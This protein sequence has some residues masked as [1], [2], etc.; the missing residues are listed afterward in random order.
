MKPK[1]P[2]RTPDQTLKA[3]ESNPAYQQ[4]KQQ[5]LLNDERERIA[6]REAEKQVLED[7][8]GVGVNVETVW[9]LVNSR[10]SYPQAVPV[11]AR[12]LAHPYPIKNRESLVRA[13]TVKESKGVADE[14]LIAMLASLAPAKTYEENQL[15]WLIG[16]ALAFAASPRSLPRIASLA[17]D[18]RYA[19]AREGLCKA[20]GG[21]RSPVAV[22][23]LCSLLDGALASPT[24]MQEHLARPF[25]LKALGRLRPT[26]AMP[27]VL[28]LV[29]SSAGKDRDLAEKVAQN[30]R[31]KGWD[32]KAE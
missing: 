24:L 6:G 9:D 5:R 13:L 28:G 30:I 8:R 7:L 15:V 26:S 20:L 32:D 4:G 31:D 27:K 16:H 23:A 17:K 25:A 3:I 18:D 19:S 1:P 11:L 14:S 10:D 22:E 21:W 12:H 29:N 2:A